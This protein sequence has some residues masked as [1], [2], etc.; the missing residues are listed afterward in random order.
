MNYFL[1]YENKIVEDVF[2]VF[3]VSPWDLLALLR[4]LVSQQKRKVGGGITKSPQAVIF[5][6][7]CQW[8]RSSQDNATQSVQQ[9]KKNLNLSYLL[10]SC[11]QLYKIDR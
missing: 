6:F 1:S 11:H 5:I 9:Q 3:T 4:K 2:S 10:K 7:F 8:G